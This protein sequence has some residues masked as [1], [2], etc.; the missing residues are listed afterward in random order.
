MEKLETLGIPI[1][2]DCCTTFFS[3]DV[4]NRIG[5]YGHF[6]IYSF[7]KFF[8]IEYGGL[9]VS[10]RSDWCTDSSA[11]DVNLRSNLQKILDYHLLRC[12]DLLKKRKNNFD[13]AL[14]CFTQLGFDEYFKRNEQTVPVALMLNNHNIIK[15]LPA[16]KVELNRNGI[17][18]SIFYGKD[19][20]F[21]P[22]HQNLTRTDIDHF[23]DVIQSYIENNL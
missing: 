6:A 14:K 11:L 8:P 1:I 19:A 5:T 2:E 22:S 3:Q 20:F 12:S 21:V 7:P 9:L 17:E 16:F 23:V 18:S 13:Y 10:H 15:N 4:S